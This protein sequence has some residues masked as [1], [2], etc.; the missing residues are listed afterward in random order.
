MNHDTDKD[1]DEPPSIQGKWMSG[2]RKREEPSPAAGR[3]KAGIRKAEMKVGVTD[4]EM[5]SKASE[6]ITW[7]LVVEVLL[8]VVLS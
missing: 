7:L 5:P 4:E 1:D 2:N 6:I 3:T 8:L